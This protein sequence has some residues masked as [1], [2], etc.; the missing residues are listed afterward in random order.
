MNI[1]ITG[2][3]GYI[4]TELCQKLSQNS[5]VNSITVLDNLSTR[6]YNLFLHTKIKSK[7]IKFIKGD[8]LDSRTLKRAL[9]D[10]DVVFHLAGIIDKSEELHHLHE[11]VNHWGTAELTYAIEESNVQQLIYISTT[12]VY[13][14]SDTIFDAE[15]TP[16]PETSLATSKW[17]GEQHVERLM[18]KINTQIVRMGDVLGYG[19]AMQLNGLINKMAF[20]CNFIGRISIP[21]NGE[22]KMAITSLKNAVNTLE[23]LLGQ[24]LKSGIYNLVEYNPSV[25]D[26]VEALKSQNEDMEMIF[27]NP[28]LQLPSTTVQPDNRLTKLYNNQRSLQEAITEM[29]KEF[30]F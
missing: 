16:N 21:G 2:G 10:I 27:T 9:K 19:I 30:G 28:H 8:I 7:K 23:N 22:Q 26:V 20:D 3:A 1:L 29:F 6:N 24:K 17:R 25:L 15:S 11:Q 4:G 12:A 14:T 13:G 5:A 18:T